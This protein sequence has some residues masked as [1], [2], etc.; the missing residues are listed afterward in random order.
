MPRDLFV[1]QTVRFFCMDNPRVGVILRNVVASCEPSP[2]YLNELWTH[3]VP[4]SATWDK[5]RSKNQDKMDCLTGALVNAVCC[6]GGVSDATEVADNN[7]PRRH[8][9]L[10]ELRD[11][12]AKVPYRVESLPKAANKAIASKRVD[13]AFEWF[14]HASC[15]PQSGRITSYSYN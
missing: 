10:R 9:S 7:K 14:C 13:D 6:I 5:E 4:F 12:L 8:E 2:T 3:E 15:D 1:A 11:M